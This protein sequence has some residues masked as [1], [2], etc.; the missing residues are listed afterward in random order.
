[1]LSIFPD[2]LP[3]FGD[4]SVCPACCSCSN[5]VFWSQSLSSRTR[6]GAPGSTGWRCRPSCWP[7]ACFRTDIVDC[8]LKFGSRDLPLCPMSSSI[9]ELPSSTILP[10]N[11]EDVTRSLHLHISLSLTV[12]SQHVPII[13]ARPHDLGNCELEVVWKSHIAGRNLKTRRN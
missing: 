13:L 4:C 1:M 5:P 10:C 12:V 8:T 3:V 7:C 2:Q 9:G 6:R 11:L